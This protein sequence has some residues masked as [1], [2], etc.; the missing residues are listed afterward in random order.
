MYELWNV[1]A[2][3]GF[4]GGIIRGIYVCVSAT[5]NDVGVMVIGRI[6]RF[7]LFAIAVLLWAGLV[8]PFTLAFTVA[9]VAVKVGFYPLVPVWVFI[10]VVLGI[11]FG[12]REVASG[13]FSKTVSD[14][15]RKYWDGVPQRCW[16]WLRFGFRPLEHFAAY[17]L[18]ETTSW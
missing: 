18:A 4:F 7:P 12:F 6:L 3:L 11:F 8:F 1:A 15:Y 14:I 5:K 17:G 9:Y 10:G 2:L 13:W 16:E